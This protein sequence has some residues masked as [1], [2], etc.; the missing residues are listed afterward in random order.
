[1]EANEKSGE[2]SQLKI[3]PDIGVRG[4]KWKFRN[5]KFRLLE[6]KSNKRMWKELERCTEVEIS[7]I[8][9]RLAYVEQKK[10]IHF[11]PRF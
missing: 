6:A 2:S 11:L 5:D 1:M 3:K 7:L 9:E 10:V 8:R 4:K